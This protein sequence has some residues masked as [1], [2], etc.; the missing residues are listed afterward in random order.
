MG[1]DLSFRQQGLWPFANV[2]AFAKSGANEDDEIQRAC[3]LFKQTSTGGKPYKFLHCWRILRGEP[4]WQD[5]RPKALLAAATTST[6]VPCTV[7]D[8]SAPVSYDGF[9][10][11]VMVTIEI[12]A[13]ARARPPS[14]LF[15]MAIVVVEGRVHIEQNLLGIFIV[16][17]RRVGV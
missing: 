7:Q 15:G 2:M 8:T 3:E 17:A 6:P 10:A 9:M 13:L 11:A 4:K 16:A 5:F 1:R 14:Y 12:G